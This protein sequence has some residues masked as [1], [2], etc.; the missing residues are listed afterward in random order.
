MIFSNDDDDDVDGGKRPVGINTRPIQVGA[1]Y[2]VPS[3]S[4]VTAID[5]NVLATE[6]M[7]YK[8]RS[9]LQYTIDS[10]QGLWQRCSRT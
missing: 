7:S 2:A 10:T 3:F 1:C 4:F 8:Q 6:P 9:V 5:A